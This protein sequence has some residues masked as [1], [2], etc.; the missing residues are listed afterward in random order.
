MNGSSTAS[1]R[2]G[3]R[4]S[5]ISIEVD[6]DNLLARQFTELEREQLPF[7]VMQ[8]CNDTAFEIREVWKRTAQRV[9]DRPRPITTNAVLYAKATKDRLYA[10]VFIRDEATGGTPPARYLLPEV[11]GGARRLKPFERL[12]QARGAMPVV[13][14][15]VP[16]RGQAL[17][18]YGNVP[19]A[20]I[21]QILSQLGSRRDP[22]QNETDASRARRRASRGSRLSLLGRRV[23]NP[24][25]Q[26]RVAPA[27]DFF[28][29]LKR[30]GGLVP[31]IYERVAS[32]FGRGLRSVL[33]FVGAAR[34]RARYDIYGLA[35]R[36]WNKL[37]PFYFSR[38]LQRAVENSRPRG[39]A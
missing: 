27:G 16:G 35:Q 38:A 20:R 6:A 21:N 25:L 14:F 17:D 32:G 24:Q 28:A 22:L 23:A 3:A 36:Q 2:Q 15:A 31:G 1:Y 18:A 11:E 5:G 37:M 29:V 9:F 12:L 13:T 34:Y 4:E 19:A 10:E 39:G 8:A 33:I 30:R 26:R 7:A